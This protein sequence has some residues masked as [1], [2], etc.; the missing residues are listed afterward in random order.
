MNEPNR[1]RAESDA[2]SVGFIVRPFPLQAPTPCL[3][4]Q[5]SALVLSHSVVYEACQTF[6]RQ[7]LKALQVVQVCPVASVARVC[8]V[9]CWWSALGIRWQSRWAY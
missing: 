6:R 5:R 7:V 2:E 9:Y 4:S 3:N 8:R 1:R